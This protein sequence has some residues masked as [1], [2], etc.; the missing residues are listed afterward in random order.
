MN[1]LLEIL[2]KY[3]YLVLFLL[4][5][6]VSFLLLVRHNSYQGSV[7]LTSANAGAA[8]I[9][10]AYDDVV[11]YANLRNV[12]RS[13]TTDNL[14]L[15]AE[16][17][18]LRNA[19][20]EATRDTL[21]TELRLRRTLKDF[22]T[23]EA[24]VIS[25]QQSGGNNYLIIDRGA[26]DGIRPEMGVVGGNGIVGIVHLVNDRHALVVPVVNSKSSISCRLRGQDYFGYLSWEGG[27]RRRVRLD[28]IPRYAKVEKGDIV[29][30]SGYSAVF[31]AGLF[32]GRVCGIENS[33]DGQGYS[34]EVNLG[35]NFSNIRN[36]SV[37]QM[38]AK[39]EVDS[40]RRGIA[41]MEEGQ[42]RQ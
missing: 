5:E 21:D 12:N 38:A 14:K 35:T 31:P 6:V 17:D 8:S 33:S 10:R 28:D 30:T 2:R 9:N 26:A 3:Y 1:N 29:E 37:V 23:I 42:G 34:L 22:Q 24:T 39:A 7:W 40:L 13:L 16:N 25:N 15:Q 11:A 41:G 36:V 19:L 18:A 20:R 4:L 32:V 27:S